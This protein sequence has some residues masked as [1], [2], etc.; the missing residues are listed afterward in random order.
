MSFIQRVLNLVHGVIAEASQ[1]I[2][3]YFHDRVMREHFSADTPYV[4]DI[5]RN[6]SLV[7]VN[8]HPSLSS[9]RPQNPNTIDVAG[10]HI[11][12]PKPLEGELKKYFDE[13]KN[14]VILFSLGTNA[15][16]SH[17][18]KETIKEI[19]SAFGRLKENVLWKF[20]EELDNLPKNVKIVKWLPQSDILGKTSL[21][22]KRIRWQ[23]V[24]ILF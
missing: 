1:R 9:P 15:Q 21:K 10:M 24:Q 11:Y 7:L 4:G 16:S 2:S 19:L 12:P 13:S 6:T 3:L 8:H 22:C 17:L 20:E 23:A 14:G 18:P 5:L